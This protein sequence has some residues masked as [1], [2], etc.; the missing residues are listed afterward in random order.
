M[1][2]ENDD[3][4]AGEVDKA[5]FSRESFFAQPSLAC[6]ALPH[7]YKAE[8]ID[9]CSCREV[10]FSCEQRFT[11]SQRSRGLV[12]VWVAAGVSS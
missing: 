1:S 5:A 6:K 10:A 12:N 11:C 2:R 4:G 3:G 7:S 9:M 8:I